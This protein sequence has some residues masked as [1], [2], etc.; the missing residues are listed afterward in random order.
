MSKQITSKQITRAEWRRF[1]S[2]FIR[3]EIK[4]LGADGFVSEFDHWNWEEFEDSDGA[5][6]VNYYAPSA[7]N[8]DSFK[9]HLSAI[10]NRRGWK[11][12][13]T[14]EFGECDIE[15]SGKHKG[16]CLC[17]VYIEK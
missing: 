3:D 8:F 1:L 16:R 7:A 6:F 14:A 13:T 11:I 2:S 10:V 5:Y 9:K 4:R 12:E 17:C 15:H